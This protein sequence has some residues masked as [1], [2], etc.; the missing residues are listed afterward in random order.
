LPGQPRIAIV[1]YWLLVAGGGEQVLRTIL[2]LFPGADVFTL[3]KDDRFTRSFLPNVSVKS[4]FLQKIPFAYKHHTKLL[5]LMPA[6]LETLDVRGY[7][8]IISSEAGPAKGILP[9]LGSTHVCYCHSPMRY[10]W[11]Q[12]EDYRSSTST[13]SKIIFSAALPKLRTWDFVTASRVDRF[14]ANSRHVQARI[15]QYWRRQSDLIFPPVQIAQFRP[16]K[17][18]SDY[19]LMS[20]RHVPYKRFDIA[21]EACKRLGRRLIITGRGRE[22][23]RLKRMAGPSIEFVDQCSRD[24]LARYYENARAF[25]MPAEED[26]GIAPVEA[27]A[28]GCPVIAF[29]RGGAL[30]T[31]VPNV[32]GVLFNEQNTE[33]LV[34]AIITFESRQS[35]FDASIIA[36]HAQQFDEVQFKKKFSEF[37]RSAL[38]QGSNGVERSLAD[39]PAPSANR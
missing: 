18:R 23:Q 17:D 37:V 31:V 16:N 30:D 12:F 26:F 19:Y 15:K 28:A 29:G 11:D 34:D 24:E 1:H 32:S 6:A 38:E 10:L 3:L 22:T 13:L 35:D 21:I 25:L 2:E 39:Q 20:G 7:D 14:A 33:G 5:T 27:M 8:L 9:D 4:S 36:E